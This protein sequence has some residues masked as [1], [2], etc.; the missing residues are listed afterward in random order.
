MRFANALKTA[1]ILLA[2]S[3]L[4]SCGSDANQ[5]STLKQQQAAMHTAAPSA[6]E[7]KAAMS[8]VHFNT[9]GSNPVQMPPAGQ[10]IPSATGGK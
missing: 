2:G 10:A 1:S 7:L 6:D 8:K 3:I 9:P 4:C 5:P